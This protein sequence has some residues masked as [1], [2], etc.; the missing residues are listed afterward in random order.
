MSKTTVV[1]TELS[2]SVTQVPGNLGSSVFGLRPAVGNSVHRN[3]QFAA[4]TLQ[5]SRECSQRFSHGLKLPKADSHFRSPN[6]AKVFALQSRDLSFS[7]QQMI[8]SGERGTI[9]RWQGPQLTSAVTVAAGR[10][11]KAATGKSQNLFHL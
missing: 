6:E 7:L 4:H 10:N 2:P 5:A 9:R 3:E 8:F 1:Y 11:S